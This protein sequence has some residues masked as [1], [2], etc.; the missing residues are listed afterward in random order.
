MRFLMI[1]PAAFCENDKDI[2]VIIETPK[3]CGN[4]YSFDKKTGLFK[5]GKILPEGMIFPSHFGF[6]PGT[7][8]EDGDPL[9]VMVLMD[10]IAYPGN[11]IECKV[12]GVIEAEQTERT[13]KTVRNDRII[14]A[15]KVS[16]RYLSLT[17]LKELDENLLDELSKFFINYNA[18]AGKK[19]TP[20]AFRGASQAIKLIKKQVEEQASKGSL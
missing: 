9:D 3:G 20:I 19:F 1:L 17:S 4:K 11:L 14:A 18:I 16:H 10:E 6:I 13:G 15:A 12:L 7:K 5:L 8:G 2:N